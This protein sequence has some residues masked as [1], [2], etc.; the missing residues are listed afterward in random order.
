MGVR[1]LRRHQQAARG[2]TLTFGWG[3]A[4]RIDGDGRGSDATAAQYGNLA[5]IIR[6]QELQAGAINHALFTV[7]RCDNANHGYPAM[8][9]GRA[10]SHIGESN[11]NAPPMS[12]ASS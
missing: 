7:I 2:G 1:L 3:G 12:P 8:K 6:A 11:T 9:S 4:T 10:C 5:G